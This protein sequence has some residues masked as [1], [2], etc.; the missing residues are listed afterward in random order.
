VI[1]I[2]GPPGSGKSTYA[3]RLAVELGL[4]YYTTGQAFRRLARKLGV[5]LAELNAMAE[6]DPRIDLEIDK[7]T[8]NVALQ[9][10]VVIDS[11]LAAWLLHDK[12]DMLVY[13]KAPLSVRARRIAKRDSIPLRQAYVEIVERESSHRRRFLK[14]Y[15]LDIRDLTIFHLIVDTSVYDVESTYR[16]IREAVRLKLSL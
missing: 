12:A 8:M 13:V 14:Y 9:G 16:I 15:G 2:S 5:S 3:E 4:R 11:H 7:E 6:K 10:R 1:I